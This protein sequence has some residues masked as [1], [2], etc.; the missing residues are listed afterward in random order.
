VT[1]AATSTLGVRR[2][3]LERLM[4]VDTAGIAPR[5]RPSRRDADGKRVLG[6]CRGAQ[7]AR[8]WRSGA[9]CNRIHRGGF[10]HH[11]E[12]EPPVRA[13]A[14]DPC[15]PGSLAEDVSGATR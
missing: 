14:R 8:P 4:N 15:E 13:R 2:G 11:W 9:R 5:S 1:V 3:G 10:Q 12:E 7:I 6:I